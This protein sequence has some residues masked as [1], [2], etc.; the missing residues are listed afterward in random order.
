MEYQEKINNALK[1]IT[2]SCRIPSAV[3]NSGYSEPH[4]ITLNPV[5]KK[6]GE[7][8]LP[9]WFTNS[10]GSQITFLIKE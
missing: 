2:E 8:V 7:K 9:V 4:D 3:F 6:M 10:H 1:F 5:Y